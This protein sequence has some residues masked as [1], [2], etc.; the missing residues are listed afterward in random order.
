MGREGLALVN[1]IPRWRLSGACELSSENVLLKSQVSN[2][3]NE[4]IQLKE[5]VNE[6]SLTVFSL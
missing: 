3:Q 6:M 4:A 2:L 5:S 1:G